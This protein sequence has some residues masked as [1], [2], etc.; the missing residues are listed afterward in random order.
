MERFSRALR[1]GCRRPIWLLSILL[2]ACGGDDESAASK[3][4]GAAAPQLSGS[5]AT[6]LVVSENYEFK[7]TAKDPDGDSLTFTITGKPRWATF[8]ATTGTL[9]GVPTVGDIGA[10]NNIEITASD[11]S[12]TT[13]LPAFG[14][15]VVAVG[16]NSVTVQ[17]QQPTT[18]EDGSALTNLAGFQIRYGRQAGRYTRTI[19]VPTPGITSYVVD[20]L[21]SGAYYFTM[22]SYTAANDASL[23]A[24]ELSIVIR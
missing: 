6:M 1:Q 22:G 23:A 14:I 8:D 5:P 15:N 18:N 10:Y 24:D 9:S 20:G 4:A 11:G 21:A 2:A 7:P 12:N 3:P 19:N 13:R 17:W 16:P